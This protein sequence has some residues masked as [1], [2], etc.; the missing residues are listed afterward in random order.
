MIETERLIYTNERG[1]SIEFSAYSPYFVNVSNDVTGLSDIQNTLYKS[2][3]MGQ[4]GETLTG[5]KIDAREIDIKGSINKQ[6]KDRV[7]ELRRA[8]L[9]VLNPELSGALTYI[10]KDFVR[11]ID[12]KVD[13]TPVFSRKK[14]FN[15]FTIQFSCPSP[16]WRE[17][18]D[19]KADIASWIGSFE[20]DLEIPEDEGLSEDEIGIEF[21][22][23][24]PNIIVDVYNEGDVS[25]GM[26]I[27]FR[28]T[29]TLSS[30]ILLNMDT[31][32]YIQINA[33]LQAG[34]VVT[35]NTEYG[36]KGATLLRGGITED[37]F[38][39]VD[40]D[41]TFMQLTI[42]DNVFRYDAESGVDAL[43]VTLYH[44]NKYLGV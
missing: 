16:F 30:P 4:H 22:Y 38:R 40:V 8:A 33:E 19:E 1:E 35:V 17:E 39:Y 36:S 7:L 3:S 37:Y 15:D 34:D 14:V 12:C 23:R 32:E 41:S 26:R 10:Y 21:D 43:E 25:T 20:F 31:G 28:A 13:N 27:E 24:E 11:V 29:G 44:S 18:Q 5:Q 6:Q 42:G 2:S 9:K